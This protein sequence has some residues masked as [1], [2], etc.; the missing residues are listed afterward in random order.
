MKEP[1]TIDEILKALC[2]LDEG[3]RNPPG[4]K[5]MSLRSP[6]RAAG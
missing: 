2:E 1:V 4:R 6:E 5:P 3:S